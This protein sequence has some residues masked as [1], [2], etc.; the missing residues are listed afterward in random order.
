MGQNLYGYDWTLPF[1]PGTV[2]KAVSPQQ[3]I[4]LAAQHNV[5][6]EYDTKAQAPFSDTELKM[7]SSMRFGLKMP[8]PSRQNLI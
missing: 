5:P 3:A 1:I 8:G 2:A 6:I 7:A 4:Q